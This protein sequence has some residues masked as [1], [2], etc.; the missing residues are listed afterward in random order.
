MKKIIF[1]ILLMVFAKINTR[2][3]VCTVRYETAYGQKEEI[4]L[5]EGD[6]GIIYLENR[7]SEIQFKCK[8]F[9]DTEVL[10][11]MVTITEKKEVAIQIDANAKNIVIKTKN[12]VN[13]K[14]FATI[15]ISRITLH[16]IELTTEKLIEHPVACEPCNQNQ[17]NNM[18]YDYQKNVLIGV[19]NHPRV[20]KP[21]NFIISNL[22]PF[23]DSLIISQQT[24][25]FNTEVPELFSQLTKAAVVDFRVDAQ[26]QFDVS[27]LNDSIIS[28]LVAW[29]SKLK[30]FREQFKDI[31][32]CY[33]ICEMQQD[34]QRK[35]QQDFGNKTNP[36]VFLMDF[37]SSNP[38]HKELIEE[39]IALYKKIVLIP[40]TIVY[41]IPQIENVDQY[42]FD[43]TILPKVGAK[44][45]KLLIHQ[46]IRINTKCGIKFDFSTG[47]FL[48]SL[49]SQSMRFKTGYFSQ[50]DL[51]GDTIKEN[52]NQIILQDEGRADIGASAL[53]HVYSRTGGSF[54]FSGTFGV[55]TTI[56]K[57]PEVRYFAG[58]SILFGNSGRLVFSTGACFGQ[59]FELAEGYSDR[60]WVL[61]DDIS[62][63]LIKRWQLRP[64][65]SLTYN[66]P[67]FNQ[68]VQIG[69]ES[70]KPEDNKSETIDLKSKLGKEKED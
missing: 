33:N 54:N 42:V 4:N 11:G 19:K 25:N 36:L 70:K 50:I 57:T 38:T 65:V 22:N 63:I 12:G 27:E 26:R 21:Y 18:R 64:F 51:N 20:G 39:V 35:M 23:Q 34:L 52:R 1:L 9:D 37:S 53:L 30:F 43:V 56:N 16:Q 7:K 15:N 67:L 55:G 28:K 44:K 10:V 41:Q 59:R 46:P 40:T 45:S 17:G 6:E 61:E 2:A 60:E 8:G 68:T 13:I 69:E 49:K 48:T 47:F 58:G 14:N 31:S 29:R 66:I 32:D 5:K 3:Q 62:N 24:L